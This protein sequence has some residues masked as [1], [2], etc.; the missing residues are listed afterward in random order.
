MI[1]G[2]S[3]I[4]FCRCDPLGLV[5]DRP[6]YTALSWS[7]AAA[8]EPPLFSHS[9]VSILLIPV[10]LFHCGFN[11]GAR[12]FSELAC[13]GGPPASDRQGLSGTPPRRSRN[14]RTHHRVPASRTAPPA[15]CSR[16]R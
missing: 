2:G 7:C 4:P 14:L 6:S 10:R 9:V 15:Q 11:G 3:C 8:S 13:R 12:G 1:V 16:H 5:T